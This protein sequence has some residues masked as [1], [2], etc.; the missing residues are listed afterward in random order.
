[1]QDDDILWLPAGP[2]AIEGVPPPTG[3]RL[4]YLNGDLKAARAVDANAIEFTYQ[5]ASR[6][7]A[8]LSRV[9]VKLQIDG[10]DEVPKWAGPHTLLLPRGQHFVTL[11]TD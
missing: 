11:T 1:V 6:A 7:I 2:H 5:S 3:P 10:A 9:P 8:I 4:L